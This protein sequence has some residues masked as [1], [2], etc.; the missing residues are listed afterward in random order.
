MELNPVAE[1]AS[2][3]QSSWGELPAD[4][5]GHILRELPDLRDQLALARSSKTLWTRIV[6]AEPEASRTRRSRQASDHIADRRPSQGGARTQSPAIAHYVQ[7][8]GNLPTLLSWADRLEFVFAEH[9]PRAA[10]VFS[11]LR[12]AELRA[13][14]LVRLTFGAEPAALGLIPRSLPVH[15]GRASV[16]GGPAGISMTLPLELP[17]CLHRIKNLSL[18]SLSVTTQSIEDWSQLSCL[19]A[20]RLCNVNLVGPVWSTL[21]GTPTLASLAINDVIGP[22][23]PPAQP[24]R[25]LTSL[26]VGRTRWPSLTLSGPYLSGLKRLEVLDNPVM[27]TVNGLALAAPTLTRLDLRG[28]RL[29]IH[30]LALDLNS[31]PLLECL[32]GEFG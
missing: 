5:W 13:T 9:T 1:G 19:T 26:R 12:L 6:Q 23:L 28:P 21:L 15:A 32:N 22:T 10:T 29:D 3:P 16:P 25:H 30:T 14:S 20:L 11:L 2:G 18:Q 24:C 17:T 31:F 4:A 7:R 27:D 8:L